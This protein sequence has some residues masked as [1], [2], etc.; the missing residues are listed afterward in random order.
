[1]MNDEQ[2]DDFTSIGT[3]YTIH[4]AEMA[5]ARLEEMGIRSFISRDDAGGAH[6]E[7]QFTQGVRLMVQTHET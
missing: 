2:S 4:D 6:P 5:Q 1:M 3:F 7:L